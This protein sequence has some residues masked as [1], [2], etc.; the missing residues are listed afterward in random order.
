MTE[1][2]FED[3]LGTF[4][5]RTSDEALDRPEI[6]RFC[7]NWT[8]PTNTV[9]GDGTI[10]TQVSWSVQERADKDRF[11]KEPGFIFG[12]TIAR[13]KLYM[14]LQTQASVSI[15]NDSLSWLPAIM[16]PEIHSSMKKLQGNSAAF[17]ISAA[18]SPTGG[19]LDS[20]LNYWFDVRDLFLY[21]DQYVNRTQ[22][23]DVNNAVR[24][25][26]MATFHGKKY[27]QSA[28]LQTIGKTDTLTYESDGVVSLNILGTQL[29]A[30]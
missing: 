9:D 7:K 24:A 28:A 20:D 8:Y 21:G 18:A 2:S 15:L 12:V 26:D 5:V 25:E 1:S 17:P 30:T 19:G 27:P 11:F 22:G 29:D 13:P 14:S 6:I 4:G 16:K 3:Y 23:A 10:N